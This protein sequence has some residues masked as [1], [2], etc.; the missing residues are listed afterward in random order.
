MP[1]KMDFS[2][3][4]R[5]TENAQ[6]LSGTT[7]VP[8][9]EIMSPEFISSVSR[10]DSFDSFVKGAGYTVLTVDDFKAIP[11]EPWDEFVRQE[12]S[13]ESW[14]EMQKAGGVEYAKHRLLAGVGG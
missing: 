11:D 14:K 8:F 7:E 6:A 12:T 2:G 4:K 10:F 1:I 9:L 5:L 13:F 3:L